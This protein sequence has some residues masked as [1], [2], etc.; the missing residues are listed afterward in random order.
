[1]FMCFFHFYSL[2]LQKMP[3]EG[4][5]KLT[6]TSRHSVP[7][8]VISMRVASPWPTSY[9]GVAIW[10]FQSKWE[11]KLDVL[12]QLESQTIRVTK[13]SHCF[14]LSIF[15]FTFAY[16]SLACKKNYCTSLD[17][18]FSLANLYH[19]ANAMYPIM[20][21][22][23]YLSTHSTCVLCFFPDEHV[24]FVVLI[25]YRQQQQLC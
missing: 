13:W 3:R 7:P 14:S 25:V 22:Q 21:N 17:F 16:D 19:L 12:S 11:K 15:Y 18:L 8:I 1:M 6:L 9:L 5:L 24:Y 23:I 4:N 20:F 10:R 2:E